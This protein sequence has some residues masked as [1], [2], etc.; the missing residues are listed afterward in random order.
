MK[1]S[2]T[3]KLTIYSSLFL[4]SKHIVWLFFCTIFLSSSGVQAT[5]NQTINLNEYVLMP[6]FPISISQIPD[7]LSGI[8]YNPLTNTLFMI[9]NGTPTI[10]ETTLTGSY[11]RKITLTGFEDTEGIVHIGGTRFAVTEEKR[12]KIT[13][14][15]IL[16]ATTNINYTNADYVKLP[17]SYGHWGETMD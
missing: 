8:T 17:N 1:N 7:D 16:A 5:Q 15:T 14:I 2:T 11:I 10:Y 6:N 13:L 4:N 12:G 3:T 9:Q